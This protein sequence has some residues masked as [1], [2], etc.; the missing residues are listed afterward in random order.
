MNIVL[1][2]MRGSGKTTVGKV[3]AQ[4][5]GKEFI[6]MDELITQKTGLSIPEIVEKYGWGKFRDIEEE[7]TD[8]VAGRDNIINAAGGGV[9]TRRKNIQE[10]KKSGVLV[11]L[12]ASV[13]TLVRRIGEDTERPPLVSGRTRRE[14]IEITLAERKL[15]Y[16]KVADLVV[17]T[18]N[19]TPE[20]VAD[21]VINLLTKREESTSD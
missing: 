21:L 2:G 3:L 5:L 4:K 20:E 8:E 19:Q 16:Q 13:D 7:I 14:D 9:V 15:L 10:L 18:E 6:E 1:I 12:T 17:D 11:W